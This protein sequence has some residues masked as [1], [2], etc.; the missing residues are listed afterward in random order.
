V[1]PRKEK[2]KEEEIHKEIIGTQFVS[3]SDFIDFVDA[4]IWNL[5]YE[6]EYLMH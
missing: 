4:V 6:R 1:E 5:S 2:E 3:L